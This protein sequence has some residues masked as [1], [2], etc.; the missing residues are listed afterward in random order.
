[1]TCFSLDGRFA[2]AQTALMLQ[3]ETIRRNERERKIMTDKLT[4][5]ERANNSGDTERKQLQ[6]RV[7]KLKNV[8]EHWS[9]HRSRQRNKQVK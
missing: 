9:G 6:D 7:A 5:L 4:N 1:M 2:S 3:E 8:S